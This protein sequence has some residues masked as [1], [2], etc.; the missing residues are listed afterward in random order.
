MRANLAL[1]IGV[2]CTAA[3][4][5]PL[6]SP[7]AAHPAPNDAPVTARHTAAA[8]S[9]RTGAAVPGS[10]QSVPLV[11]L[12]ADQTTGAAQ[13]GLSQRDTK[14]FSL[15]GV[16]WEE[17]AAALDG[18]VQVRTRAVA[19]GDWSDWQD[20]ET[21]N[22]AHG[23]DAGTAEGDADTLRGSTAPLWVNPSDGVEV[24]VRGEAPGDG[25]TT[26]TPLPRGLRVDLVD[27][28]DDPAATPGTG[29]TTT[30]GNTSIE[31]Q[32]GSGETAADSPLTGSMLTAEESAASAVNAEHA[33]LG[34]LEIPELSKAET[35]ALYAEEA[36]ELS[37]QAAELSGQAGQVPAAKP[38]VGPRPGITTRKGWGAD[39]SMREKNFVY[40]KSVQAAFV[41]HSATGNNYSCGQSASVLRGIYRYHVKSSGWRDFGYN[42]A[43]DKCGKIYEGRAG[44]VAKAVLG[45]HTLGFN[46]NSMGVVVLGTY[47]STTPP[48]AAVNG[49]A[50]LTAWKLGLWGKNPSGTVTLT[51]GGSNLYKKGVRV[52]MNV[53]S[54]HRDGFSTECP[55]AKLYGR[56]GTARSTAARL[57][58]R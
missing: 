41:H 35:E 53:I 56:L 40:T 22:E 19:T 18:T 9:A 46:S 32:P 29:S 49:V 27:P 54:G 24:R 39:E 42:F 58:G 20:L 4:V 28:G 21:H 50:K 47:G 33:P 52:K 12:R 48:A 51:S 55:G 8:P 14:P 36:A 34:A 17:P 30:P 31:P 37:E 11:G 45:A 16:V 2:A 23:A 6:S 10:T 5:I 57:Q 7:A 1:A 43:V 15:L 44:G 26:A 13:Q 38:Y 25:S 3:L